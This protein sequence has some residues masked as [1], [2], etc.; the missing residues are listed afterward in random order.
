MIYS[1][2]N[3]YPDHHQEESSMIFIFKSLTNYL[4]RNLFIPEYNR[5]VILNG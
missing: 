4:C 1:I 3:S 5:G 2:E